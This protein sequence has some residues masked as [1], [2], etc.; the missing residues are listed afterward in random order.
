M[1]IKTYGYTRVIDF[2]CHL[3]EW[4]VVKENKEKDKVLIMVAGQ[5][6][7]WTTRPVDI[8]ARSG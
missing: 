1:D 6:D 8:S 3:M 7:P 5:L 2:V 4:V